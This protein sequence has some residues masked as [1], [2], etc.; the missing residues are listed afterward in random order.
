MER[1]PTHDEAEHLS[2]KLL[3]VLPRLECR[4]CDCFQGF[5]TQLAL[6]SD[7]D[8][9]AITDPLTVPKDRIHPC[10]GCDPCPPAEAFANTLR[11]S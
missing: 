8:L 2:E 6:D 5:L 7:D 1:K 11:R 4:T 9:S 10:L 3:A